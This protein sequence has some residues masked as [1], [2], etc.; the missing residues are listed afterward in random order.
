[1]CHNT[2]C[3]SLSTHMLDLL[4]VCSFHL[5]DRKLQ[6]WFYTWRL[7]KTEESLR[8]VPVTRSSSREGWVCFQLTD[9]ACP[10]KWGMAL[11]SVCCQGKKNTLL[12]LS[13]GPRGGGKGVSLCLLSFVAWEAQK[14]KVCLG[15]RSLAAWSVGD[16]CLA[17][18][19]CSSSVWGG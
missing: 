19:Q 4:W 10:P 2:C 6:H 17:S 14:R 16:E 9:R 5:F 8:L 1:M 18:W 11:L 13:G 12:P 3:W 15:R 7:L